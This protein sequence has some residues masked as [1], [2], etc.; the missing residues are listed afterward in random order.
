VIREYYIKLVMS[1]RKIGNEKCSQKRECLNN[2]LSETRQTPIE[3]Y[4]K[5]FSNTLLNRYKLKCN[6]FTKMQRDDKKYKQ[7]NKGNKLLSF[8]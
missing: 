7:E 8:L 1:N 3:R 4:R 2:N 5:H 6:I